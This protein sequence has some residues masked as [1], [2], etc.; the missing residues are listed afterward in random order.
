MEICFFNQKKL[1][2]CKIKNYFAD[3]SDYPHD[4]TCKYII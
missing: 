4:K 2:F 1:Y 3:D